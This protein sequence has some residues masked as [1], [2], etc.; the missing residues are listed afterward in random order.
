MEQDSSI[1]FYWRNW[2]VLRIEN[3]HHIPT[4]EEAFDLIN[5]KIFINIELKG[6]HTAKPV[7]ALIE[8]YI[9]E[10]NWRYDSF[11][12]SSFDW[13]ALQ[14]IH[15]LNPEIPLGVLTST[16][17]DL[18][19]GFAGFIKAKSIHPYF[20]LLTRENALVMQQKGFEVYPWTI[21]ETEDIL[22]IKNF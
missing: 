16:D 9:L 7:L 14:E 5:Q 17:I 11:L 20:H 8:K 10:K 12:V 19:I 1:S 6:N 22:K 2:K 21:N 13:N 3:K 18:A 15:H 4:L